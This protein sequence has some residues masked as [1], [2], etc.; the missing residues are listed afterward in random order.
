[1]VGVRRGSNLGRCAVWGVG[2]WGV[3]CVGGELGEGLVGWLVGWLVQ[4][5]R[6]R[7]AGGEVEWS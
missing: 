3:V 2:W 1:V 6:G 5:V 7:R 4:C